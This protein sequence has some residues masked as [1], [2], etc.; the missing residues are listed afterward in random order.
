[1]FSIGRRG[2]PLPQSN[3]SGY[4]MEAAL[5]KVEQNPYKVKRLA[6]TLRATRELDAHCET[7]LR[8]ILLIKFLE[9]P[10]CNSFYSRQE[11]EDY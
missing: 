11:R 10:F 8:E 2:L 1:M 5:I 7:V 9:V 4:E 3:F 6:S